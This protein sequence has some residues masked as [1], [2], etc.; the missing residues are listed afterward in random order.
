MVGITANTPNKKRKSLGN[1]GDAP[2]TPKKT[3]SDDQPKTPAINNKT[4]AKSKTPAKTPAK[5]ANK[6]PG[7]QNKTP[8]ASPGAGKGAN[9]AKNKKNQSPTESNGGTQKIKKFEGTAALNDSKKDVA[10]QKKKANADGK[11]KRKGQFFEL[12]NSLSQSDNKEALAKLELKIKA[13]SGRKELTK[14][15]KRKLRTLQKIKTAL[16][17]GGKVHTP[18]PKTEGQATTAQKRRERKQKVKAEAGA[19]KIKP[20]QVKKDESEDDEDESDSE[21]LQVKP[22]QFVKSE[23]TAEDDEDESGEE[24][25]EGEDESGDEEASE[26]EDDDD[27]EEDE[28]AKSPQ[29]GK[30][31]GNVTKNPPKKNIELKD[32]KDNNIVQKDQKRYVL[33]VGNLPYDVTKAELVEHFQKT[34]EIRHIRIPTDKQSNKPRGFAYVELAN[35]DS[36]QR[37]L[38]LHHTFVKGRRINVLYTQGGKKQGEEKKKDV[39][40]KNFKLQ[41]MR[42]QG[43]L[44][45]SVKENQKRS[46]RRNKKSPKANGS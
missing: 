27:E 34:G 26:E 22:G 13:I 43:Q 16:L 5:N 8:K 20:T 29:K 18:E 23:L 44:A 40:S 46:F 21:E 11:K 10:T 4:P 19:P 39:K 25:S 1:V 9:S 36:Y 35:E 41:A 15:A 14:T 3:K 37:G 6:T 12:K 45:G 30:K 2:Q 31:P 17:G 42:K 28:S 7:G 33:F 24:E 32:L 38:S